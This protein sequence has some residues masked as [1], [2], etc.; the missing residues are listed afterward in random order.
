MEMF[1]LAFTD[2]EIGDAEE[3]R[4]L[5]IFEREVP[6][7]VNASQEFMRH[8]C[9]TVKLTDH[10]LREVIHAYPLLHQRHSI[11]FYGEAGRHKSFFIRLLAF[12]FEHIQD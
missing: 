12:V 8:E 10:V 2:S 6:R 5:D 1:V 11:V 7:I 4:L 9:S 3:A